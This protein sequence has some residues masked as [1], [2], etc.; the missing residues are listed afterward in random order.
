MD[1]IKILGAGPAGLA[2]A[3]T[4]SRAGRPVIVYERAADVGTRHHGDWE[5]LEN[6]TTTEDAR[7]EFAGWGLT[8]NYGYVPINRLTF[9]GPNFQ[10]VAQLEDSAPLFYM[11]RRGPLPDT[12]DR[13]L[14]AQAR[15]AGV[16]VTFGHSAQPEDVDIVAS[17]YPRARAFAVGYN[18]ETSAP[19][20][21]Y[22]CL[23]VCRRGIAERGLPDS[24]WS[25]F[26][27]NS[28]LGRLSFAVQARG[29]SA[30]P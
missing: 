29:N 9:F 22:I 7:E 13:G 21:C 23:A 15:A 25:I 1:A 5:A 12:F 20:G 3:I 30:D 27:N 18:F 24:M 28:C 16:Q 6:W 19:N 17:G 10:T 11:I 14:L 8:V 2:A 26:F 4:L